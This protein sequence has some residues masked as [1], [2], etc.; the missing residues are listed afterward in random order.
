MNNLNP[1]IFKKWRKAWLIPRDSLRRSLE[2]SFW[3]KLR[4]GKG[5]IKWILL[6]RETAGNISAA[7]HVRVIS[8]AKVLLP[9]FVPVAHIIRY[10]S[11]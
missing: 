8:P 7:W 10:E 3:V 2:V 6:W 9:V 4:I 11:V 5:N 1:M